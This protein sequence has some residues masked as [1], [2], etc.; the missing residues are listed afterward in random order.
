MSAQ[1]AE[2]PL[3]SKTLAVSLPRER[4]RKLSFPLS[5][6]VKQQQKM[7]RFA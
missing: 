7:M 5:R 2:M 6:F 4:N 1:W 3:G